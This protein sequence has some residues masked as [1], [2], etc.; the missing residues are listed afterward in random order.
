MNQLEKLTLR[1]SELE[2][3]L[4]I[5]KSEISN[6]QLIKDELRENNIN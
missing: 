6:L 5:L 2:C 4:N 1:Q 3:E